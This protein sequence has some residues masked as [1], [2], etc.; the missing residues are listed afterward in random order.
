MRLILIA[1]G[2]GVISVSSWLRYMSLR[3]REWPAAR[4]RIIRSVLAP[5]A[6][7]AD[8]SAEIAYEFVVGARQYR[9][10]RLAY[11]L[12]PHD[13][14]SK[15]QRVAQFPVGREVAVY[16]DP[17]DPRRSVLWRDEPSRWHWGVAIGGA[18]VLCGALVP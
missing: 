10:T 12:L 1:L 5:D 7:D 17:R 8:A 16:Y 11:G 2:L 6:H 3:A 15:A 14:D 18:F 9:S 13:A 4:G